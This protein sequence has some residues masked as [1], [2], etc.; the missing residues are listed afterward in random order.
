MNQVA[1]GFLPKNEQ[2]R[3]FL[4]RLFFK[5][6]AQAAIRAL[7]SSP[8]YPLSMFLDNLKSDCKC[9]II[10]SMATHLPHS[11][12]RVIPAQPHPRHSRTA[13]PASFPHSPTRVIPAQ[14]H[15]RHSCERDCAI[16]ADSPTIETFESG[17]GKKG[18][19]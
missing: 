16:N 11:P 7:I 19:Y 6:Q 1:Q 18:S 2:S 4:S 14:P 9:P 17:T 15:P 10:G 13:P 12:T 5:F 8:T 3:T